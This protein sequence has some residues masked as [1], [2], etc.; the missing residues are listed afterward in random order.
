MGGGSIITVK[1]V[2]CSWHQLALFRSFGI[3]KLTQRSNACGK[4]ETGFHCAKRYTNSSEI[5]IHGTRRGPT[6]THTL[7]LRILVVS[8]LSL[9]PTPKR[10]YTFRC[11]KYSA[12]NRLSLLGHVIRSTISVF[13]CLVAW[14]MYTERANEC[15]MQTETV[16][17]AN[18]F[19]SELNSETSLFGFNAS[20]YVCDVVVYFRRG[21]CVRR[22]ALIALEMCTVRQHSLHST[23]HLSW[24]FIQSVANCQYRC[25]FCRLLVMTQIIEC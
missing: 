16:R 15:E 25:I 1:E 22:I 5:A 14:K 4:V 8:R 10:A 21:I 7:A 13:I 23:F 12:S 24:I 9:W 11:R 3:A 6:L 18:V 2:R 19:V 17:N 20:V